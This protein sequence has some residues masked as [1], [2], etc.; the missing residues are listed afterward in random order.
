MATG[1]YRILQENGSA[2]WDEKT[3]TAVANKYIGF[4]GS[5][6]FTTL[7]GGGGGDTL[8]TEGALINSATSKTTPV[9]ADQIGLMD[10]AASNILKKLSWANLKAT[11]KTYFDTLYSTTLSINSQSGTSYTLVIGDSINTLVRC[12]NAS[13]IT[14]TLPPN[15]G[16]SIPVGSV[17]SIEQQGAGIVTV[18]PG[19]GVTINTT[20]RKT[21]G[22]NAVIQ[23]LKVGTDTWNVIN[24]TI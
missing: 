2:G 8:T 13:A 1:D 9:D 7:D 16:V 6:N 5:K 18:A 11:L 4:D 17:I 10:S 21:W 23:V 19:S 20:A 14:L 12:N 22:Q 15:S 24:G 3:I